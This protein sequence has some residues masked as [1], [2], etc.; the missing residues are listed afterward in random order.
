MK[1]IKQKILSLLLAGVLGL[2]GCQDYS[3]WEAGF[4]AAEQERQTETEPEATGPCLADYVN[5]GL[6][7]AKENGQY[8]P[9][10]YSDIRMDSLNEVPEVYGGSV[11]SETGYPAAGIPSEDEGTWTG[12]REN[13]A[14]LEYEGKPYTVINDSL[15][16][17]RI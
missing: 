16:Y 5:E 1:R 3:D 13:L 14:G 12:I 15:P 4:E 6:E 17:F 2:S 11:D 8:T 9:S 10:D 7:E